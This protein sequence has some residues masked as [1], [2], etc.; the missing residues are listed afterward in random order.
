MM[1]K[2]QVRILYLIQ[3]SHEI[4]LLLPEQIRKGRMDDTCIRR[5]FQW[6]NYRMLLALFSITL[7]TVFTYFEILRFPLLTP[8]G[9][10]D[11]F[12]LMLPGNDIDSCTLL[13]RIKHYLKATEPPRICLLKAV[14]AYIRAAVEDFIATRA[15]AAGETADIEGAS[16]AQANA[17]KGKRSRAS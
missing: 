11:H 16:D 6:K 9:Y 12:V 14:N 15:T 8:G 7:L 3:G 10:L 1:G 4:N 2:G 13:E 17:Q 5:L